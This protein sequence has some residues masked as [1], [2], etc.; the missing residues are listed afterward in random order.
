MASL[1]STPLPRFGAARGGL[2]NNPGVK[3]FDPLRTSPISL[4]EE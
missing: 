4:G 2:I 3:P 1:T